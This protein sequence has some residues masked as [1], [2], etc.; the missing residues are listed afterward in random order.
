[1]TFDAHLPLGQNSAI[2]IAR[3]VARGE[4]SAKQ[5]TTA[6]LEAAG[7]VGSEVGA[8]VRLTPELALEQ[9]Q[10]VDTTIAGLDPQMALSRFPLAGVPVPIK[11]L[12]QVAGEGMSA[13]S[14]LLATD[15]IIPEVDDGTVT[16][17]RD[18]GATMIGKTSTPEFGFPPYT[19]PRA[20]PGGPILPALTPWDLSRGAGGSS[21]GAAAAVAAGVTPLAQA[22]DG[23]GSIRIPAAACGIVGFKPSR[24]VV[25]TG[26]WSVEGAGLATAGAVSRT[27]A[28]AALA[29]S[30][31]QGPWPGDDRE[32]SRA[33]PEV[34]WRGVAQ[35]SQWSFLEEL[36]G[37][38]VGLLTDPVVA[39]DAAVHPEATRAAERA[40]ELLEELGLRV[41]PAP[42]PF[43]GEDWMAFMPLWSVMALNLPI[44]QQAESSLEPL[45]RW[46]RQVGRGYTGAQYAQAVSAAQLVA[47]QTA[48]AWG[49]FDVVITP[50]LAGP[51]APVG[52]L[53]DDED[54]EAE[55]ENQKR[56]TPWTSIANIWGAPSVSLPV[57]QAAVDGVTLPFGA[58][59]TGRPGSDQQLLNLA[60]LVELARPFPA[61][62]QVV[63]MGSS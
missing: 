42:V 13:G 38:R 54:P 22:S 49:D 3:A 34:N 60:R 5:V 29:L 10:A 35:R 8:F 44:P 36:K 9:A 31:L 24:G 25:S 20:Y 55:F 32:A 47:R 7:T 50:T 39:P 11:D 52:A 14:G 30:V 28:D 12:Y 41:G 23:G 63:G 16:K 21:G 57:H 33:D 58:M 43:S 1:M 27:V 4:V 37:L 26:P 6:A 40:A 48:N 46:L 56:F 17:L 19:E 62:P 53:R 2:D 51:P 18:A 15:P 61:P 45:T 59:L